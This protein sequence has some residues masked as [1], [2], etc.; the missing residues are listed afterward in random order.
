MAVAVQLPRV[1]MIDLREQRVEKPA[2]ALARSFDQLQVVRPEEHDA[3]RADH[4]AR[5]AG[6]AVHGELAGGPR[7]G[8]DGTEVDPHL[9]LLEAGVG[10]YATGD[11]GGRLAETHELGG[12]L[13]ARGASQGRQRDG[14]EQ[15]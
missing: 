8:G 1:V 2:A 14:L 10:L 4:V 13:R 3:K 9:Q 7:A 11:T 15:V 5:S 12:L 6:D